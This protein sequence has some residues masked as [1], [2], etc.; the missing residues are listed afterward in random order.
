MMRVHHDQ[1]DHIEPSDFTGSDSELKSVTVEQTDI[2]GAAV[3]PCCREALPSTDEEHPH[4]REWRTVSHAHRTRIVDG[5]TEHIIDPCEV[6]AA[7]F[8][9]I[10]DE[11]IHLRRL[12]TEVEELRGALAER[13]AA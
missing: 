5:D 10:L 13:G 1:A 7:E 11:E 3:C 6:C 2:D 4:C 9:F 8:K 12:L